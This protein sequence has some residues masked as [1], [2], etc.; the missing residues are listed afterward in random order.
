M[1][2]SRRREREH[3]APPTTNQERGRRRRT[4]VHPRVVQR[5]VLARERHV[6]TA[7]Q[8]FHHPHRL[9][10]TRDAHRRGVE[11]DPG[12]FVLRRGMA[13]ADSELEPAV[14][15]GVERGGLVREHERIAE[16]VV[17]HERAQLQAAGCRRGRG[18]RGERR[19][20]LV[21]MVGDGQHVEAEVFHPAG[22]LGPVGCGSH[23]HPEP[24]GAHHRTL[25]AD[26]MEQLVRQRPRATPAR[27]E[28]P[29]TEADVVDL[30]RRAGTDGL[31]VR[32]AGSRHS[33]TPLC[34]TDGVA[35][36][37]HALAGVESVDP[38]AHTAT[39]LGGTRLADI[40]APL[41]AAGLALHNQGDVDTQTITGAIGTGT[42]GTG[43][44]LGNLSSAVVGVRIVTADGE[45]RAC[46][47]EKA[48]DLYEAARLS[49]GA[50]GIITAVTISCLDAYNLYERTWFESADVALPQLADRI[51][52]TRHY[53]F[54]WH[55]AR[56]LIENKALDMTAGEPDPL[57]DRKRER[58]DHSYIVF[59]STRDLRFN[60][61]EYAVP[62]EQGPACFAQ[63]RTLIQDRYPRA[64]V[65]HR[66]PHPRRRRRLALA[67][68]RPRHRH[69]LRARGRDAPV[70]V[71]VSRL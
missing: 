45:V 60:E 68:A 41:R 21:E 42:H 7:E 65:A 20:E 63:V 32:P 36:D 44:T 51:A 49:L 67:R 26:G 12:P 56:D 22:R 4:R 14:R 55:P 66:V 13:R 17:A 6:L 1:S 70:R 10:Q 15:D 25:R 40:G 59:P 16:V 28:A 71:A 61:M 54:W 27:I 48:P 58:I 46:S 18:Q 69:D 8:R 5:E 2:A 47:A 30:V 62:A 34:A 50:L 57:P 9:R 64:P 43:P 3:L 33:F 35:V 23:R 29:A 31:A 37:L 52:E 11:S 24:K 53:E 38:A 39:V 19:D